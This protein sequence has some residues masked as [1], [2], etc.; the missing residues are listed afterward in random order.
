MRLISDLK[1]DR[2]LAILV[3]VAFVVVLQLNAI[4]NLLRRVC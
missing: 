1:Q 4:R 2:T 3:S